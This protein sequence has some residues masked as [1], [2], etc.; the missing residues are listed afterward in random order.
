M[1]KVL[2]HLTFT[3]SFAT[4]GM[5]AA[6]G[7]TQAGIVVIT[8]PSAG[9]TALSKDDVMRIFLAKTKTY[10]N[11]KPAVPV[12]PREGS[13][14]RLKFES[15]VFEKSPMQVKAYWTRLLFTGRGNP[16]QVL[17]SDIDIRQ[18]VADNP[19]AVGYIDSSAV[20]KSVRVVFT[21]Q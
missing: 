17:E 16:P 21:L 18:K 10:P 14:S 6:P 2:R 1:N 4:L 9:V 5:A 13:A 7:A 15:T 19:N 3:L 11:E 12:I 8:H 20:D